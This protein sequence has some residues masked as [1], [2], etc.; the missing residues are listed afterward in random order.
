ME[1]KK[2]RLLYRAEY[3]SYELVIFM[4]ADIEFTDNRALEQLVALYAEQNNPESCQSSPVTERK[5]L[6]ENCQPFLI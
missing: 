6:Y 4:D 5:R 1:R 2:F 3:A